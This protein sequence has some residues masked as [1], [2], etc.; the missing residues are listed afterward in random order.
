MDWLYGAALE[1][2]RQII[3]PRSEDPFVIQRSKGLARILKVLQQFEH[4]NGNLEELD[5]AELNEILGT[6]HTSSDE[7]NAET[8][9]VPVM[10]RPARSGSPSTTELAYRTP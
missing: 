1:Q 9:P 6:S 10:S 5:L 4:H 7:A 3:V 2:I 8:S